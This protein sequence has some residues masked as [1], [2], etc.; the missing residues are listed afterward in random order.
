M[1]PENDVT[2]RNYGQSFRASATFDA[3]VEG[4]AAAAVALNPGDRLLFAPGDRHSSV[5]VQR[6]REVAIEVDGHE[7]GVRTQAATVGGA[8]AD[9][10]IELHAGDTVSVNGRITTERPPLAGLVAASRPP[11]T[12]LPTPAAWDP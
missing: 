1:V 11:R 5:A 4:L 10:G 6:S 3:Q 8:L 7:V 2:G 12:R 9:A